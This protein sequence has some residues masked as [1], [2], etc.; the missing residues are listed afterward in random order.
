MKW[1]P[2][3]VFWAGAVVLA[4]VAIAEPGALATIRDAVSVAGLWIVGFAVVWLA[5]RALTPGPE[6]DLLRPLILF[7]AGLC[8]YQPHW[9]ATLGLAGLGA[10]LVLK[11]QT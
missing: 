3:Q 2:L 5:I 4:V 6:A 9:G 10:A 7:L 11:R 8:V 1:K